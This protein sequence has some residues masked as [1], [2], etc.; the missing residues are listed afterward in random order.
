LKNTSSIII[1]LKQREVRKKR[2][3][4]QK[5]KR[6]TELKVKPLL[7]FTLHLDTIVIYWNGL[8]RYIITAV[9][10]FTKVA[11]ARMYTTNSSYSTADFLY[12]LNYLLDD[13]IINC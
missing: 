6:I 9:D 1:R 10:H 7:G 3:R 11:L 5:K 12:R 2:A 13:K 8:K 4:A